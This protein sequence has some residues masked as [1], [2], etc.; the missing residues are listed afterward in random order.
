M[1]SRF[2]TCFVENSK[3]IDKKAL[4][5][6]VRDW[7]LSIFLSKKS[8]NQ[9]RIGKFEKSQKKHLQTPFFIEIIDNLSKLSIFIEI[10][11]NSWTYMHFFD[12]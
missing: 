9:A 8:Q 12:K 6:L 10:I 7:N 4:Q 3:F 5:V 1:F 11:D 2:G